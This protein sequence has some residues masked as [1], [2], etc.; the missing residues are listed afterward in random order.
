MDH[1]AE[2]IRANQTP[3]TPGEGDMQDVAIMEAIYR[4]AATGQPVQLPVVHGLDT[5]RGPMPA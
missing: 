4:A 2:C 3:R 1:F 5:T